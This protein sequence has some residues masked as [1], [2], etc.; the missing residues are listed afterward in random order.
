M[1][2]NWRLRSYRDR[3]KKLGMFN[4]D[5]RGTEENTGVQIASAEMLVE[6]FLDLMIDIHS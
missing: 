1:K 5:P 2:K 3:V 6:N 4:W